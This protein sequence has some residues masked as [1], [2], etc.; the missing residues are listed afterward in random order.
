M[1]NSVDFLFFNKN[2]LFFFCQ[3]N[4]NLKR[5]SEKFDISYLLHIKNIE[6]N[7]D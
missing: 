7:V 2:Y 4:S 6:I 5:S 3:I 1:D